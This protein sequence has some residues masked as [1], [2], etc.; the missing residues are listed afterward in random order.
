MLSAKYLFP[1]RETVSNHWKRQNAYVQNT[2]TK[3]DG[4]YHDLKVYFI[5][6]VWQIAQAHY[7]FTWIIRGKENA[8]PNK[9]FMFI[10]RYENIL[11]EYISSFRKQTCYFFS[12]RFF[13][14][15]H[16]KEKE[17][18]KLLNKLKLFFLPS[19]QEQFFIMM[20]CRFLTKK[21]QIFL[22]VRTS[23]S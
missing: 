10:K 14:G 17:I 22:F 8:F 13:V 11:R 12:L 18:L 3:M 20:L 1:L 5:F 6:C 19:F 4:A 21:S 2:V 7:Y 9:Y 15:Y 23:V 16:S